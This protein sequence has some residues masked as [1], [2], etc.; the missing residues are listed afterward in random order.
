MGWDEMGWNEMGW[1][2][3]EWDRMGLG[4][5]GM[6]WEGKGQNNSPSKGYLSFHRVDNQKCVSYPTEWDSHS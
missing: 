3:M 2:G 6:G 4:W 5:D 1:D